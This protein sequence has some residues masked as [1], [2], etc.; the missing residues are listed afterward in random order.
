M[1]RCIVPDCNR[2]P[3]RHHFPRKKTDGG[4]VTVKIC[5]H[6]HDILHSPDDIKRMELNK[7]LIEE[8]PRYWKRIGIWPQAEKEFNYW[9]AKIGIKEK[10]VMDLYN[11]ESCKD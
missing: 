2:K 6:H 8:A 10:W 3:T 11:I 7:I 4:M 1:H 5:R 9:L